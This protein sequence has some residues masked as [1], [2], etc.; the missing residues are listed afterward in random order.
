MIGAVLG[1]SALRGED[2]CAAQLSP[3]RDGVRLPSRALTK[4]DKVLTPSELSLLQTCVFL[5]SPVW[6]GS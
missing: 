5:K 6:L 4:E 2:C 3:R 1:D